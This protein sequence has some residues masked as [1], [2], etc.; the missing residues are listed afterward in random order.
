MIKRYGFIRFVLLFV[1]L[2]FLLTSSFATIR[3]VPSTYSKIQIAID[4]SLNG[5]TIL[6]VNRKYVENSIF[7]ENA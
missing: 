4:P 6:I 5:G 1:F 7:I 2:N 3:Y